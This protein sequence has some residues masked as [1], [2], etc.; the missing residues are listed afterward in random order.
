MKKTL[1]CWM[2]FLFVMPGFAFA[3][4]EL[5]ESTPQDGETTEEVLK[6]IELTFG[7]EIEAESTIT[8]T[9]ESG[10]EVPVSEM[11]EGNVVTAELE[12][13]LSN[14]NYT[15]EWLVVGEDG[16]PVEGKLSF[17]VSG[18]EAVPSGEETEESDQAAEEEVIDE[19]IDTN[20]SE[21]NSQDDSLVNEQV[22]TQ[23]E[24]QGMSTALIVVL[25]IVGALAI[26]SG[27]WL[28]RRKR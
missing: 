17:E 6:N 16:H 2:I 3:H 15:A 18:Q 11:V 23:T 21:G 26:F 12:E 14:G 22:D 8:L 1:I 19:G 7:T 27:I 25:L 9:D 24:N 20:G 5:E 4:T 10:E 28:A 13:P